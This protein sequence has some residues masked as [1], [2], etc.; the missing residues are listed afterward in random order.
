MDLSMFSSINFKKIRS[1]LKKSNYLFIVSFSK[2]FSNIDYFY[3]SVLSQDEKQRA[4]AYV[5]D[6]KKNEFIVTRSFL[7]LLLGACLK[8]TPDAVVFNHNSYGKPFLS[9]SSIFF[10]VSHSGDYA[11]IALGKD[12]DIGIDIER[13]NMSVKSK[14]IAQRFFTTQEQSFLF[15]QESSNQVAFFY[16]IWTAKEAVCKA[17]GVGLWSSM[18][19]FSVADIK[20][21]YS[22]SVSLSSQDTQDV[23]FYVQHSLILDRYYCCLATKGS[24]KATQLINL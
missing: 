6:S 2:F 4:N 23:L 11:V 19:A 3:Q 17:I 15:T 20:D 18:K 10:N 5:L 1:S 13:E 24:L 16:R 14:K 22:V 21:T 8:I 12:H 7:R 9:D